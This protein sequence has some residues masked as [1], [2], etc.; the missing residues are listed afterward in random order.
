[1]MFAL[2]A[3]ALALGLAQQTDTTFAVRS[4]G[5]LDVDAYDGS[6]M[7]R[8]W[9]REQVRV[10]ATHNRGVEVQIQ[11]TAAGVGIDAEGRRGVALGVRFDITVPRDYGVAIDGVNITATVDGVHGNVA[12]ENVEGAVTIRNVVGNV[13]IESVSGS[14]LVQNVRGNVRA[15]STNQTVLITDARGN[16]E[17]ETV[18][19]SIVMRGIDAKLVEASTIN[20]IIE[21]EGSLLDEGRY[22]L[23]AHN[24][25]I[26]MA[27]PERANASLT[28]RTTNG[29]VVT[30]FPVPLSGMRDNRAS[31]TIGTGGARV[32]LESHNGSI[33][34]VRPRGR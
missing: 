25:S 2:P 8:F 3:L 12:V 32:E 18:N 29:R 22:Y 1:M 17:A 33:H 23:G 14:V 28:V 30:D 11:S 24:G 26:T 10:Q 15:T 7:V 21:Y 31:F 13:A 16:I 20:G 4:G 27:I 19:G 5:R 9:D 34:L 6:V